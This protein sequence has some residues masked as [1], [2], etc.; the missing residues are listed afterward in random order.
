MYGYRH[1]APCELQTDGHKTFEGPSMQQLYARFP[2]EH[3]FDT[4]RE[5][6]VPPPP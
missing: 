3:L 1:G 2:I 5:R 6:G 4:P